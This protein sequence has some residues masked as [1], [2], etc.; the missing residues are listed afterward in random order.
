MSQRPIV[1]DLPEALYQRV[2]QVAEASNRPVESVLLDSLAL[3]FGDLSGESQLQPESLETFSD[4]Q[5]WAIVF[6]PLAWP[7]DVRLREL[8]AL[9]KSGHLSKNERAEMEQL[10]SEVDR[11]VLLRSQALL[12]LKQRGMEISAGILLNNG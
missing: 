1:L 11:F 10:I 9:G 3:L 12:L 8:T 2:R 5:L 6:R 7:A 4:T